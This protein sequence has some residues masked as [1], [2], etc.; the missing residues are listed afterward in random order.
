[1]MSRLD[2]EKIEL[3][4]LISQPL[5]AEGFELADIVLSRYKGEV[6]LR[7]FFYAEQG[8]LGDYARASRLVGELIEGTDMF[9]SGYML[10]V[11]S[12]GL[13]RP[14]KTAM[15]FRYRLGETVRISFVDPKRKKV[16]A[17]LIGIDGETIRFGDDANEF[18]LTLDEIEMAKIVF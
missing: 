3:T 18:D 12:P 17:K 9:A 6:T 5:M 13:D 11:S 10:E 1:M 8:S 16:T 7:L 2:E 14:L 15:D 4:E